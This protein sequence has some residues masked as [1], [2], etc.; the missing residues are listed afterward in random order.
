MVSEN[1]PGSLSLVF[2]KKRTG[3]VRLLEEEENMEYESCDP[4]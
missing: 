2:K 3:F 1:W 4:M